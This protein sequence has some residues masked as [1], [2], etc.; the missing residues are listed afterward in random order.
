MINTDTKNTII[1]T[2]LF[3][4]FTGLGFLHVLLTTECWCDCSNIAVQS[5]APKP[6]PEPADE[7]ITI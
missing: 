2:L 7:A 6:E 1:G 3:L 4:F 5:S